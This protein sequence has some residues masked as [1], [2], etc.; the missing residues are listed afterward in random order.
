M[1]G[2]IQKY[3]LG[4]PVDDQEIYELLA[5]NLP[6]RQPKTQQTPSRRKRLGSLFYQCY[7]IV[8]GFMLK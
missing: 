6:G 4:I 8:P 2:P 5:W 3:R 7:I 1:E